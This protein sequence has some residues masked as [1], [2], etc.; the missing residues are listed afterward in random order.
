MYV[1]ICIGRER[2]REMKLNEFKKL[3]FASFFE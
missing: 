2:V 3:Q 1:Y